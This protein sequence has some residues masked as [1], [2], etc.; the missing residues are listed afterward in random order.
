MS[1]Q[2]IAAT[3]NEEMTEEQLEWQAKEKEYQDQIEDLKS[4]KLEL[5]AQVKQ[6]DSFIQK[7]QETR[8]ENSE[9]KAKVTDLT[10]TIDDYD[11]R[12]QLLNEEKSRLESEIKSTVQASAQ[13]HSEDFVAMSENYD[14][15]KK[16][17]EQQIQK[18]KAQIA[19]Q[20]EMLNKRDTEQKLVASQNDR[21]IQSARRFFKENISSLDQIIEKFDEPQII[22]QPPVAPKS[23]TKSPTKTMPIP[24]TPQVD[25]EKYN[26]LKKRYQQAKQTIA[27]LQEQ[28]E[29]NNQQAKQQNN[30]NQKTIKNLQNKLDEA[31]ENARHD[32]DVL[33]RQI[34]DLNGK[35]SDL[36]SQ[37]KT[38]AP[39]KLEDDDDDI[40][41]VKRDITLPTSMMDSAV[42]S[43]M[44]G[45]APQPSNNDLQQVM[46]KHAAEMNALKKELKDRMAQS[47]KAINE[48]S[49]A[50][51]DLRA[52]LI[53]TENQ[54]D[55]AN[56]Q[57][58]ILQSKLDSLQSLNDGL[59]QQIEGLRQALHAKQ[60][61]QKPQSN[62]QAKPA[63][64]QQPSN[65]M[66][67]QVRK[68]KA[69]L[70]ELNNKLM[71]QQIAL[72][73]AENT[74]HDKDKTLSEQQK[75]LDEAEAKQQQLS[76]DLR[77]AQNKIAN[78]PKPD[79]NQWLPRDAW[80]YAG[81][82]T[83]L[84]TAIDKIAA[85]Q[86]LLPASKLTHVFAEIDDFFT[87]EIN[88]ADKNASQANQNFEN[89]KAK[90]T[91]FVVDSSIALGI[92]PK[93]F[94]QFQTG[95]APSEIVKAIKQLKQEFAE[96]QALSRNQQETL[97]HFAESF[98]LQEGQDVDEHIDAIRSGIDTQN[99]KYAA[100][101]EK[102]R[103]YKQAYADLAAQSKKQIQELVEE[104]ERL[105]DENDDLTQKVES[106]QRS[107][108]QAREE[109]EQYAT[110]LNNSVQERDLGDIN[111]VNEMEE[112][113][114]ALAGKYETQVADLVGQINNVKQ[115][116]AKLS[117][118]LVNKK[119]ESQELQQSL[120]EAQY[121][122]EQLAKELDQTVEDFKN[123][124]N[125]AQQ[126]KE[127]ESAAAKKDFDDVIAKLQKQIEGLTQDVNRLVGELKD[128]ETAN[129][130]LKG[131]VSKLQQ[132]KQRAAE[133]K[134]S[135]LARLE[136]EVMLADAKARARI[137][138][139]KALMDE[140]LH[141]AEAKFEQT[142]MQLINQFVDKFTKFFN[143][144]QAVTERE[145]R[146]GVEKAHDEFQRITESDESIR[147]M[148][149]AKDGQTTEDA[150]AQILVAKN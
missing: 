89:T 142:K 37:L 106:T 95:Q 69:E 90:I 125:Q 122:N 10:R 108:M 6:V 82:A 139:E 28:I 46:D 75:K 25:E 8:N 145:Y 53:Q 92:E 26:N 150:V 80:H 12:L 61:E 110:Q 1:D 66:K 5:E 67:E 14:A 124:L 47:D 135:L 105:Q 11:H 134:K 64:P 63:A 33:S 115:E 112:R 13:L 27:Q 59:N 121:E 117:N 48:A 85:N 138:E 101:Y 24:Q 17:Y 2:E 55:D 103:R 76:M 20:Q 98:E 126:Q 140:K 43:P 3:P 38:P 49:K 19:E 35:L 97:M 60:P 144:A 62:S 146:A 148:L 147:K 96:L 119:A 30:A 84:S 16:Q 88:K 45:I 32:R 120:E 93:T 68:L 54:R 51:E 114:N 130:Q 87:E 29:Q 74:I 109:T 52:K 4:E 71:A 86:S 36:K 44:K 137:I 141:T 94:E 102:A 23:P 111:H 149:R 40:T 21:L 22:E 78:T 31:Q 9:L 113:T 132:E 131:Q 100:T 57:N 50:A 42:K 81:F 133:E 107:L 79:P 128:S 70:E 123:K 99:Q 41:V 143:P 72:N 83:P 58:K 18:L 39:T 15:S 56:S 91:T 129:K 34:N 118:D 65:E 77:E 127:T 136:R 7:L 73:T 116:N 104:K